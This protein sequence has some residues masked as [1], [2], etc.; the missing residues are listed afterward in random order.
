MFSL[1]QIG[2]NFSR[3]LTISRCCYSSD[4]KDVLN[5]EESSKD[6]IKVK[7]SHSTENWRKR[8]QFTRSTIQRFEEIPVKNYYA[9]DWQLTQL[10]DK[11]KEIHPTLNYGTTPEKWNYYNKVSLHVTLIIL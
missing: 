11:N 7:E 1:R 8:E 2:I 9:P 6:V 5:I 3:N 4:S 10:N